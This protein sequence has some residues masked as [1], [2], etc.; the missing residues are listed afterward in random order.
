MAQ[1]PWPSNM[2]ILVLMKATTMIVNNGTAASLVNRPSSNNTPQAISKVPVKFA[3]NAG[4]EKPIFINRPE[5][6]NAGKINF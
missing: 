2:G 3:Q 1:K 6:T 4:L 5:P